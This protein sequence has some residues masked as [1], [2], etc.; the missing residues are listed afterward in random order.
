MITIDNYYKYISDNGIKKS[1]LNKTLRKG[2]DYINSVT[3]NG[4]SLAIVEQSETVKRTL[5]LYIEKLNTFLK[6]KRTPA[7]AKSKSTTTN[8]RVSKRVTGTKSKPDN[9]SVSKIN[10]KGEHKPTLVE[11]ISLELKF[12]KRFVNLHDK[13]KTKRQI[14]LFL[15]AVQKA[16]IEKR[17]TKKSKFAVEIMEIQN[18]LIRF[19]KELDSKGVIKVAL[20][21]KIRENYL[22]LIG[23]QSELPSARFIKSYIN[24][25][26]QPIDVQKASSLHNRIAK[27]VNAG[28]I[29]KRDRYWDQIEMILSRLKTFV[30][31]NPVGGQLSV[32][33]KTLNGLKSAVGINDSSHDGSGRV[34]DN[35]IM[36]SVDILKLKFEKL[37]FTGKWLNFIGNPTKNFSMMIYGQPKF[38]K[39]ILAINFASYLANNF[40]TVLYIAREEG[41]DDT[42]QEK[43]ESAAHPDLFAVGSLPEDL[44]SFDFIFLDSV[45]KL[46]LTPDQID[47]LRIKY[48]NKGFI[49]VF[50]TRK[51][52]N[53]RGSQ[54]FQHDVDIVVEVPERGRAVQFGRYNQGGEIKIFG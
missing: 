11:Q 8:K 35:V 5:E 52:G 15:N 4:K 25:Q 44:E 53:F 32:D 45:N 2:W 33:T 37:G 50:Q 30:I 43:L 36:S 26:G 39:S 12:I 13:A 16:I 9:G 23:K 29:T 24:L 42:L 1:A 14:R 27:K 22:S 54:E 41:I 3:E 19:M 46:G 47:E 6:T 40:G 34:P 10:G 38:G 17:I 18:R 20:P 21:R 51:D 31:D 7:K 49:A 28:V 48:P